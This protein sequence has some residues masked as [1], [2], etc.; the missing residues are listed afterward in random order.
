MTIHRTGYGVGTRH[1]ADRPNLLRILVGS[2]PAEAAEDSLIVIETTV[3]DMNPEFY[4]HVMHIL[5]EQGALDVFMVPVH[6]K[7]NRPGIVLTV[8][9][10]NKDRETLSR[11]LFMQT[12]TAGVRYY[13]I[14][15]RTLTRET[16]TV[17]TAWGD[18]R[19]KVLSAPDG[20]MDRAPEYEDCRRIASEHQVPLKRV[21]QEVLQLAARK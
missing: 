13:P 1:L 18:V 10:E 3:D 14:Q 8:V 4:D 20:Q 17:S 12:S 9:A 6:M 2:D 16:E 11:T 21:Y 19:V 5:F 7:K 15:R